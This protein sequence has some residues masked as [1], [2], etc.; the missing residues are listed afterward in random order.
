MHSALKLVWPASKYLPGYI[1]A[2][3][4]GFAV[5]PWKQRRGY[6]NEALRQLLP[7]A[8]TVAMSAPNSALL[9]DGA[10]L[11]GRSSDA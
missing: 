2:R 8:K 3:H 11:A 9:T 6:A 1:A 4:I 10:E 5:V 7:E